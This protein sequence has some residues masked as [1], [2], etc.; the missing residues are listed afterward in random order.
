M[1]Q[2]IESWFICDGRYRVE[3]VNPVGLHPER[4]IEIENIDTRE[5]FHGTGADLE[6]LAFSLISERAQ[7]LGL[8]SESGR[9]G[10]D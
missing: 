4:I 10:T 9:S 6:R 5:R 8:D 1:A 7:A 2:A 3:Y